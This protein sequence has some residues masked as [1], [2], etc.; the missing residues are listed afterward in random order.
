MNSTKTSASSVYIYPG[1]W[2]VNIA[3]IPLDGLSIQFYKSSL[4]LGLVHL[5]KINRRK[6]IIYFYCNLFN[7]KKHR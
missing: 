7:F 4:L 1:R 2:R 6:I 5:T 3:G